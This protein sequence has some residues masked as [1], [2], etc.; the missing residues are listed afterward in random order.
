MRR[1]L[2]TAG[3]VLSLSLIC[4]GFAECLYIL[5]CQVFLF[6]PFQTSQRVRTCRLPFH[7]AWAPSRR[8]QC[9]ETSLE[10]KS[11]TYRCSVAWPQYCAAGDLLRR[12]EGKRLQWA[13]SWEKH[14]YRV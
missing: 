14:L 2:V 7:N 12:I 4:G 10:A 9:R 5:V 8:G 1:G 3:L 6:P 13:K 11:A